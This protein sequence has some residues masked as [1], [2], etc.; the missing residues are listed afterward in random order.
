MRFERLTDA[1]I[2][3]KEIFAVKAERSNLYGNAAWRTLAHTR[4]YPQQPGMA[5]HPKRADICASMLAQ[6]TFAVI[7]RHCANA[8]MN[9]K[10]FSK[11]EKKE[12]RE[13]FIRPKQNVALLS[14]PSL[15]GTS[16]FLTT[17]SIFWIKNPKNTKSLRFTCLLQKE[18]FCH[19]PINGRFLQNI[20]IFEA[21]QI[22]HNLKPLFMRK[23]RH[24]FSMR[25]EA[26]SSNR[27]KKSTWNLAA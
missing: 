15:Q 27:V 18:G 10:M 20:W 24:R 2:F 9:G 25:H 16:N 5:F 7:F 19:C 4:H 3:A 1:H 14:Q 21:L 12:L 23:A 17:L 22:H 8:N 13:N 26:G 6:P 11:K